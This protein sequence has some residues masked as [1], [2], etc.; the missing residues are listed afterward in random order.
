MLYRP[1]RQQVI[2]NLSVDLTLE[3]EVCLPS[4]VCSSNYCVCEV[5]Q[6]SL[7]DKA[8]ILI[9]ERGLWSVSVQ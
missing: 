1:P 6:T 9:H 8:V 5:I 3:A 4:F 2:V 7:S